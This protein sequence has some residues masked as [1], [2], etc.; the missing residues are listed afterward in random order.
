MAGIRGVVKG[1]KQSD[2]KEVS[3][4]TDRR[5]WR[6]QFIPHPL[7]CLYTEECSVWIVI[8]NLLL[9]RQAFRE[10][11]MCFPRWCGSKIKSWILNVTTKSLCSVS[12]SMNVDTS[13]ANHSV[14]MHHLSHLGQWNHGRHYIWL[15]NFDLKL[16]QPYLSDGN[17][18]DLR[19]IWCPQCIVKGR[20]QCKLWLQH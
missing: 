4:Q 18:A 9:H 6:F 1:E 3:V 12:F 17:A 10:K 15:P 8:R 14:K 19:M 13:W 5:P 11:K 7:Y 2:R 20:S 16:W